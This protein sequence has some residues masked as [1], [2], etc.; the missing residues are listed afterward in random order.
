MVALLGR[1]TDWKIAKRY[2]IDRMSVARERQKRGIR[3]CI[4][5]RPVKRIAKLK[6]ILSLP[7]NL[8]CRRYK[9]STETVAKLRHDLDVPGLGRWP[10]K[11]RGKTISSL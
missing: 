9:M 3:P 4:E 7:M 8:I 5:T 11:A 6:P 10:V 1:V 2:K